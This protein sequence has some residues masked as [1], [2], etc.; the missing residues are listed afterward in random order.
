MTRKTRKELDPIDIVF[1]FAMLSFIFLMVWI[2]Y[3][4]RDLPKKDCRWITVGKVPICFER[5]REE[6][7]P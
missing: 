5:H 6:K 4:D 3:R 1:G 7:K 2:A